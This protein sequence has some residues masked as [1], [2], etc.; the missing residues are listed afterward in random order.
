MDRLLV[1][2]PHTGYVELIF[3]RSFQMKWTD[4]SCT[5]FLCVKAPI[6]KFAPE[7]LKTDFRYQ[8]IGV[9]KHRFRSSRS[10]STRISAKPYA[11]PSGLQSQPQRSKLAGNPEGGAP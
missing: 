7:M 1:I 3:S 5:V 4:F 10:L 8:C 11:I 9:A 6:F 2:A